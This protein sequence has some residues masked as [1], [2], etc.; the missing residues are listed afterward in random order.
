MT[1]LECG[2][3]QCKKSRRIS[4]GE[5]I[6]GCG[7]CKNAFHI[8]CTQ[9]ESKA[10]MLKIF[11][12]KN[13]KERVKFYCDFCSNITDV[14]YNNNSEMD[15]KMQKVLTSIKKME[16]Q[17]NETNKMIDELRNVSPTMQSMYGKMKNLPNK[18]DIDT[19]ILNTNLTSSKITTV[20]NSMIEVKNAMG[21]IDK[22][23]AKISTDSEGFEIVSHKKK[24]KMQK[25]VVVLKPN[26]S[27]KRNDIK[28]SMIEK[29]KTNEIKVTNTINAANEK[30]IVVCENEVE[31]EK[32]EELV[33]KRMEDVC[34][35][36]APEKK[37]PR[38]KILNAE[39]WDQNE[40][41]N[42]LIEKIIKNDNLIIREA[43]LLKVIGHEKVKRNGRIIDGKYNITIELDPV[44]RNLIM[45]EGK[46]R[47]QFNN[48]RVVDGISVGKC[49]KCFSYNHVSK[50][51]PAV[52]KM[53]YRCGENHLIK[54]CKSPEIICINCKK[55]N[56]HGNKFDINH[57][58]N[59]KLCP[60]Y[61]RMYNIISRKFK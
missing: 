26:D 40:P 50:N 59:D 3:A 29:I 18:V 19:V 53:C 42:E 27:K 23:V 33:K 21:N 39:I 2:N 4:N 25:P 15:E 46:I 32:L 31:Q 54:E 37:N 9:V 57:S 52:G 8:E 10:E 14:L 5:N 58:V 38:L 48:L 20:E 43:E 17:L 16:D 22:N 11:G 41:E 12:N 30:M 61:N 6:I 7:S 13:D 24:R 45:T 28:K 44:A 34:T 47:F 56:E 35:V 1:R 36:S 55:A 49:S 60:C 51:C